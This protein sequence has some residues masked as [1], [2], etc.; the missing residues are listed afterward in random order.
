MT[1]QGTL[2]LLVLD[3]SAAVKWYLPEDQREEAL[4]LLAQ[5]DNGGVELLAPS[6]IGPELFNALFQQYRRSNLSL[7]EA[8]EFFSSFAEA[9]VSFFEIDSLTQRA[10]EISLDS[11]VIVYDALFLAL[12]E[13][14]GAVMVTADDRLLRLL[15]E[16]SYVSLAHSLSG[17]DNL[18]AGEG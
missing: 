17:V 18:L 11:G 6:T 4:R 13:D 9:P 16:T 5:V 14:A 8:R 15:R 12:A 2:R 7:D 10:V 3:T 1:D